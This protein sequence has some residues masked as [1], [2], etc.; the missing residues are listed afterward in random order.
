MSFKALV[1][2]EEAVSLFSSAILSEEWFNGFAIPSMYFDRIKRVE[3][4]DHLY[5]LSNKATKDSRLLVIKTDND[6]LFSKLAGKDII[7]AFDRILG[8][9][10]SRFTQNVSP[11]KGW[12]KYVAGNKLSI[13]ATK[14]N[15]SDSLRI[16]FDTNPLD[17]Q[18]IY[19]YDLSSNELT[20]DT[21]DIDEGTFIDS[22][23]EIDQAI[24]TEWE[25]KKLDDE[26][27]TYGFELTESLSETY[28][29]FY[30][31]EEWY[32]SK[33]TSE[34]RVFVDKSYDEPV[35]LKGAAGTGK[36]LALTVKFL[37]DAYSFEEN[38]EKKRLLFITHSHSTSQ[39]VLDLIQSMDIRQLWGKFSY[40]EAKVISLYD[41]A[42]DILN[43]NLKD[44]TPLSTD[45]REG[46]QLQ[47]EMIEEIIDEK[48]KE[49]RFKTSVVGK[50][51]E[52]FQGFIKNEDKRRDFILEVLN[53][54]ACILDAENIYLGSASS[55]KYLNGARESWQMKLE[56]GNDR[57][58]ILEL[59]N[60]YRDYLQNLEVLSMDQMIADLNRYLLSH[61]W[62]HLI[63]K[64]GYDGIFIDELHCF[65][66]PER[67][68]FHELYRGFE[69]DNNGKI[70][71]FMAYDVKQSVN[72]SFLNSIK[73]DEGSAL[74]KSTRV[75]K[76]NLVELTKVFRYTPEIAKFLSD[77]DGSFPALDL[78]SEWNKLE[79]TTD[80]PTGLI[81]TLTVF[82][83]DV[84]LIDTVFAE[85]SR[86]A[87]RDQRKSV[88]IL[89]ANDAIFTR[90]LSVG[91]IRKYHEAITS[92]D[93]NLKMGK[94]KGKC[95]FSMPQYVA[96]LQFDTVYII[97]MDKNEIDEVSPHCGSYRRFISQVY[98][99][100]SRAKGVLKLSSSKERRGPSQVLNCAL[101][102]KSLLAD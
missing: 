30:T 57:K 5:L 54:F 82:D 90:Y 53:E 42:Q 64:D 98:L 69:S 55:G 26:C 101:E 56:K 16:F 12:G 44:L 61:E 77:I 22:V 9:A 71:L 36:T 18:H 33:L 11:G 95:I 75:G 40:V 10:L 94:F 76:S 43:Y 96:G 89:C 91:R 78:A 58:A 25:K 41:L 88:A 32:E 63:K 70:P 1:L 15:S 80:N 93:E 35:R 60:V 51:S 87:K 17:T 7:T 38:K 92:R 46:R 4:N 86:L 21:D 24:D 8:I 31:L 62:N 52:H 68:V 59:H 65:T 47:F 19:A 83:S 84:E 34:Q 23:A 20:S 49:L 81:P 6:A 27:G 97:H 37:K 3:I 39:L 14:I 50:C 13:Y 2:D 102:N 85:A 79:L 67:M 99:G 73:A 100:A 29:T 72:D 74:M 45:G 28:N 48:L 66:R